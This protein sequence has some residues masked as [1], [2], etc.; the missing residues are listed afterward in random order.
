MFF[1]TRTHCN[2]HQNS[3][4]AKSCFKLGFLWFLY[5]ADSRRESARHC[6]AVVVEGENYFRYTKD[7]LISNTDHEACRPSTTTENQTE[8]YYFYQNILAC[9][10]N[11]NFFY[12]ISISIDLT[13]FLQFKTFVGEFLMV[14]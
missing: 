1:G 5:V 7:L 8:N 12:F 13:F 9:F 6:H 4:F 11:E 14:I 3:K 10:F 2:A